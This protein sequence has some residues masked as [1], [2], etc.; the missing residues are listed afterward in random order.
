MINQEFKP[1]DYNETFLKKVRAMQNVYNLANT[2]LM[3]LCDI[4]FFPGVL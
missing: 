2:T 1:P 3:H 4:D